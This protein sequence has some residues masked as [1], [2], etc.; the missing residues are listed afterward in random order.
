MEPS[1]KV[2]AINVKRVNGAIECVD[3]QGEFVD[4]EGVAHWESVW[5]KLTSSS[6]H[7]AEAAAALAAAVSTKD[8]A[9]AV[10]I[11]AR[12]CLAELEDPMSPAGSRPMANVE[13]ISID[14]EV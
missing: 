2:R 8:I 11:D 12:R 7:S 3:W 13:I 9:H 5:Y 10:D 14:P 1:Y 6:T 4:S